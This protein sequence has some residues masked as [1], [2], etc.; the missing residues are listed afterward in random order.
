MDSSQANKP[1]RYLGLD[2]GLNRTGYA[3][4]ERT[5]KGPRLIEGGVL[6]SAASDSLAQRVHELG[7]GLRE[8]L[9]EHDPQAVAIEQVFS[10]VRNP[11][12]AI[13]MALSLIHISEPTRPY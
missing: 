4:V 5:N 1:S 3:L 2:P 8:V 7:K 12:T 6:R 9:Q 13:L 11:K 10:M